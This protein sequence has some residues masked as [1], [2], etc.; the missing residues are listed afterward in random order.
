VVISVQDVTHYVELRLALEHSLEETLQE[1]K[2]TEVLQDVAEATQDALER[3]Q[4]SS[5]LLQRALLPEKPTVGPGYSIAHA[6]VAGIAAAGVGGDFYDTFTT[7]EGKVGIV[8]GDVSG[9]GPEAAALA[10]ATRSTVRAFAYEISS[11]SE[12]LSHTNEVL[13]RQGQSFGVFVTV[14]L[15]ILDPSTGEFNYSSAGHPPAAICHAVDNVEF[16]DIHNPVLG[17]WGKLAYQEGSG[18]LNPGEKMVLYT[19]GISEARHD[20]ELFGTERL[21]EV[22]GQHGSEPPNNLVSELF[23]AANTWAEG[24]ITD[25]VAI[26]IIERRAGV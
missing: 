9:K 1:S 4:R 13:V 10:V 24:N 26:L 15:V 22:L 11:P 6:Y 14:F 2:R 25:D 20:S 5:H 8:I 7:E 17:V 23:A 18:R 16:L 21:E 12:S 19:D 3:E